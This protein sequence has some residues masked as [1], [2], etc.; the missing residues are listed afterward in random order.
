MRS[1]TIDMA[2]PLTSDDGDIGLIDNQ[3]LEATQSTPVTQ[4]SIG[5][6]L[7]RLV[8]EKPVEVVIELFEIVADAGRH[9]GG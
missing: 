7:E 1:M 3:R 4:R 9:I 8:T 2:K 5:I 6:G